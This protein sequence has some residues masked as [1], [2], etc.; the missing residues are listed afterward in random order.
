MN[1]FLKILL[2][3]IQVRF[4]TGYVEVN[5]EWFEPHLNHELCNSLIVNEFKNLHRQI[6]S[7][8]YHL[9]HQLNR[10]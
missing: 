10:A 5:T 7:L 4:S 2:K 9:F 8:H 3:I 6:E 1:L